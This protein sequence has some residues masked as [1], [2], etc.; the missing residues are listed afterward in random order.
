M[1]DH[2]IQLFI[3]IM[4]DVCLHYEPDEVRQRYGHLSL[5]EAVFRRMEE[6]REAIEYLEDMVKKDLEA[7]KL[8]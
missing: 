3:E 7:M 2:E 4:A 5:K 1:T 8:E 6:G